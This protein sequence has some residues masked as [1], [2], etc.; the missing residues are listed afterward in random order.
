MADDDLLQDRQRKLDRLR[1]EFGV[2][3]YGR[4]VDDLICL[5]EALSR[6]DPMA[7]ERFQGDVHQDDRPVVKTSGRVVQHRIMGNLIFLMVRDDSG[8]L[9]LAV[10]KKLVGSDAFSLAKMTDYGDIV[11]VE[12]PLGATKT[13]Q[14][15][16]W[17]QMYQIATKS[18]APP[19]N[20]WQGLQDE[21]QRYRRRYVDLYANP[22][23]MK[24]MR[25]R[26]QIVALLRRFLEQRGFIEVE[27]PILQ[28][29]AGGAAARPFITHHNALDIP[30]FMRV[31]PEL[32]LKRLLVGGMQRVFELARNF[33]NEG[34]DRQHNPEFTLLEVYE[35][36]GNYQ[37]MMELTESRYRELAFS[38]CDDGI[39]D[40]GEYQLDFSAAFRRVSFG[41]LFAQANGFPMEAFG[42]ARDRLRELELV[43][44]GLDDW[45]VVNTLFEATAE[46]GLIQP[47]F[48]TDYPS[49]I[50]PLTRPSYERPEICERWDLFI[51]EMEMG[52]AY[53]ELNDPKV[54]REKFTHQL[55]GADDQE[56]TFRTLDEDF[57]EALSV[58]MPPAGGLGLGIDRMIMVLTGQQSIRDVILFPLM[59]PS[60]S[61]T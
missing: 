44:A 22:K 3:P 15:S 10:S 13:G 7:D 4:R 32:Y 61:F 56:Q 46:R 52:T 51:G 28:S 16:I 54:Q 11:V 41:E 27:T 55:A 58:G 34:V 48:V 36:F 42:K 30:L 5:G 9:Q 19:P 8:D 53:T 39:I 43:E 14:I 40:W 26:S 33:R 21:Q 38:I 2:D 47:T 31:A 1:D 49:Q 23:V 35:A 17:A 20:K 50:S 24:T 6:Y 29:Q 45:L 25:L 18:L 57:L 59:R 60:A 37:T 12:G